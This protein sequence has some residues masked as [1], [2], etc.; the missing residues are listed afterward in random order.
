MTFK[1]AFFKSYLKEVEKDIEKAER[2][3][4]Q[5]GAKHLVKVMKQKVNTKGRSAPGQAPGKQSGSLKKGIGYK[6]IDK[7]LA[8]VGASAPGYVLHLMELGTKERRQAK[9]SR[10]T[11]KIKP[12]PFM[13]P[14]FREEATEVERIMSEAWL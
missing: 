7:D 5:A 6:V 3:R 2:K 9:T 11:G 13:M 1:A 8:L 12:R 14:T 4:I 10:K